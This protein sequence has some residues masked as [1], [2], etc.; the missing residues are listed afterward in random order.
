[1]KSACSLNHQ[2]ES[3]DGDS[4]TVTGPPAEKRDLVAPAI[5]MILGGKFKEGVELCE[6]FPS[7]ESYIQPQRGGD[8]EAIT[9]PLQSCSLQAR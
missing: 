9:I 2:Q 4:E 1:V 8:F 7:S 5:K 3:N 6:T